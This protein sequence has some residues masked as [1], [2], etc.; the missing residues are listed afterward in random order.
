VLQRASERHVSH[1]G[2]ILASICDRFSPQIS[3]QLCAAVGA[4][5]TGPGSTLSACWQ[6]ARQ[7]VAKTKLS[8]LESIRI[9]RPA[10]IPIL[11]HVI[12]SD[13]L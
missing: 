11:G 12:C 2:A 5:V 8:Y 1:P 3:P 7:P 6:P 13:S 10:S 4:Y 9:F